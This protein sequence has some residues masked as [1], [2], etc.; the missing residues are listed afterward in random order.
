MKTRHEF[1]AKYYP[2]ADLADAGNVFGYGV[3]Y[4]M[5]HVLSACGKD[6]SRENVMKQAFNLNRLR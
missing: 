1:I 6:L 4:T 5:C 3:A 2:E